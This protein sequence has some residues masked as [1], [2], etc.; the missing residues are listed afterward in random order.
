MQTSA[1]NDASVTVYASHMF[2]KCLELNYKCF[3]QHLEAFLKTIIA[4]LPRLIFPA[5]LT[6]QELN[7]VD[8]ILRK[9]EPSEV[10]ARVV[11]WV[12]QSF[13]FG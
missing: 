13:T 1:G 12:H 9:A 5:S 4:K 2:S 6:V 8:I 11:D 7:A 3:M 10:C